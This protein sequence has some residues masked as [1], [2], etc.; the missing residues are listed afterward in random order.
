[1]RPGR[2]GTTQSID[3]SRGTEIPPNTPTGGILRHGAYLCLRV[4]DH[5]RRTVAAAAVPAL[6]ERLHFRSEF[7][8]LD[9]HPTEAVAFLR[10]VDA[11]PGDLTDDQLLRS[12]A[13]IHVASATAAAVAAF[14]GECDHLLGP[15]VE[16]RVLGGVVGPT[17]YT[18]NAMH[19]FAY[20]HQVTQQSALVM[21]HAFLL[22]TR[23]TPAWWAKDWMERHTYFLPRYDENG[24]MVNEG[25]ALAAAAGI[26]SLMRRTYK[27]V[28]LPAPEGGYDFLNY[29]ECADASIPTFHDVCQALRNVTKNPEWRYVQEGPTW[30]G[31]RVATWAELFE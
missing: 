29:F 5:V 28:T 3:G 9:G 25:H 19:D 12:D 15:P 14:C 10:R 27:N 6:T 16:R 18:G 13:V 7:D 30:H 24:Q 21:P 2:P 22:P 31:R 8:A 26:P 17:N 4:P 11:T 23:K 20:A 1:M